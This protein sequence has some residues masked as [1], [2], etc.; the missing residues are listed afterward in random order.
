MIQ[1]IVIVA[2]EL[3]GL[4]GVQKYVHS[5]AKKFYSVGFKVSL[6]SRF[7]TEEPFNYDLPPG[8]NTTVIFDRKLSGLLKIKKSKLSKSE[9][10]QTEIDKILD[11]GRSKLRAIVESWDKSVAVV[12]TQTGS[13]MDLFACGLDETAQDRPRII[14]QYH[15]TYEYAQMQGYFPLIKSLF[16]R[17]DTSLF[18]TE[19]D[20]INFTREGLDNS[21]FIPNGIQSELSSEYT[22]NNRT[23]TAVFMG[24]ISAEK[25]L[26][27]LLTAWSL[28]HRNFADWN[29]EIYGSGP[30]EAELIDDI[31]RLGLNSSAKYMGPTKDVTG[32]LARSKVH[33]MSS[34]KEGFPIVLLEAAANR[35]PSVIYNSGPSAHELVVEGLNGYVTRQ[36]TP[37]ELAKSMSQLMNDDALIQELSAGCQVIADRYSMNSIMKKWL[38]LLEVNPDLLNLEHK[39]KP[40]NDRRSR[41]NLVNHS[42]QSFK[43]LLPI[44]TKEVSIRLLLRSGVVKSK[45]LVFTIECSNSEGKVIEDNKLTLLYSNALGKSFAYAPSQSPNERKE[46]TSLSAEEAFTSLVVNILPWNKNR[47]YEGVTFS[48]VSAQFA[49]SI[50]GRLVYQTTIAKEIGG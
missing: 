2:D 21:R 30:K 42:L 50:N 9:E 3:D 44:P 40:L 17:A 34:H 23:N 18:L 46:L 31:N 25:S 10:I 43:L 41:N 14:S 24:R 36:N 15:G 1:H 35:T 4:G 20:A 47:K 27:E 11:Q 6:I 33:V 13:L 37:L 45:D 12:S 22:W 32:V 5:L 7:H 8:I 48:Q 29:L 19:H 26:G 28:I 16:P 39:T 38:N 49:T